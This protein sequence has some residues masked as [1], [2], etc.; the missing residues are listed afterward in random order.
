MECSLEIMKSAPHTTTPLKTSSAGLTLEQISPQFDSTL[1]QANLL[2]T[3]HFPTRRKRV[4]PCL[5]FCCGVVAFCG[6]FKAKRGRIRPSSNYLPPLSPEKADQKTLVLDLDET[7]VHST[8][9]QIADADFVV[10]VKNGPRHGRVYVKKRPGLDEFLRRAAELYEV[11]VFTASL[12]CYAGLVL[13]TIDPKHYISHRLFREHCVLVKGEYVKDLSRLGRDMSK[14]VIIDV[15]VRQNSPNAYLLHPD[16]GF[17]IKSFISDSRDAELGEAFSLL[18]EM[19][20]AEDVTEFLSPHKNN[21][22]RRATIGF[23]PQTV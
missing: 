22:I 18:R 11:V 5:V 4:N 1:Q 20:R 12:E 14:V 15:S 19:S 23:S 9:D 16:N 7:L 13:D 10:T 3:S 21:L 2:S 8:F 17:P 6:R